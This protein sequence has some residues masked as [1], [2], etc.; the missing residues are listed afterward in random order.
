VVAV[1]PPSIVN[2]VINGSIASTFNSTSIAAGRFIWFS[3][4]VDRGNLNGISGNVTFNITNSRITFTANNQVFTL[5]VP[6]SRI[7]FD[8]A[9]TSATTQFINNVWETVI[10]RSYTGYVF[11]GGLNYQVPVNLPGN[12]SNVIWTATI[13]IDKIGVRPTWKWAAAVYT[14]LATHS[15]LNIK[16]KNGSTQN[17]YLNNDDAG[18]P[19]NYKS[20]VVAGAKGNGGTNYTGNYSTTS[21][22]TCSTTVGQRSA[23][24]VTNEQL[25]VREGTDLPLQSTDE[26]KLN[27]TAIPNPSTSA[28]N[29]V[30]N[31]NRTSFLSIKVIDV[32]GRVVER[33]EKVLPNNVIKIGQRLAAG[34]YFVEV[35]QDGHK[36]IIRVIKVN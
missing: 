23:E 22:A 33:H 9:V 20:F 36:K 19:E 4:A 18:T 16:P 30:V 24:G 11:M 13:S 21:S 12:I 35:R 17:P 25:I 26:E 29:L 1:N 31:G 28:F 5:N 32:S 6:N 2:C 34:A 15:G 14:S 27:A 3:S 10:P 8:A 7:R